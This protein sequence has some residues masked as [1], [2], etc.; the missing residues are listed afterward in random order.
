MYYYY[1]LLATIIDYWV[2]QGLVLAPLMP[3]SS[4]TIEDGLAILFG[5]SIGLVHYW[6]DVEFSVN[7][8][9]STKVCTYVA[10]LSGNRAAGMHPRGSICIVH[11]VRVV[12][13]KEV[14]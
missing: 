3:S 5:K 2:C 14:S 9:C 1:W 4:T 12:R 6:L 8:L 10:C 7:S 11:G 13:L